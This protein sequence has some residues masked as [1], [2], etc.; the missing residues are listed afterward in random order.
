M[1]PNVDIPWSIHG[2]I[3]EYA[4]QTDQTIE[5]AY[6]ETLE[7][8]VRDLPEQ[9]TNVSLPSKGYKDFGPRL[10]RTQ[11]TESHEINNS[12][13]SHPFFYLG[14]NSMQIKTRKNDMSVNEFVDRLARIH[15]VGRL[16]S[17]WFTVHQLGGA[18]VG[19]GPA[20]LA[21]AIKQ[22]DTTLTDK[23]IPTYKNGHLIYIAKLAY[24]GEYLLIR[25]ELP[26]LS[27]DKQVLSN[28]EL[29]FIVEGVPVTGALYQRLANA[30]G[31]NELFNA[32]ECRLPQT[33][34]NAPEGSRLT[35]TEQITTEDENYED[36]S[37]TGLIVENPLQGNN[38]LLTH[39]KK[40]LTGPEGSTE[41]AA[42]CLDVLANYDE[43]YCD[44][45]HA[46]GLSEEREYEFRGLSATYIQPLFHRNST[47]NI[48]VNIDW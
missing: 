41:Q 11:G 31:F 2:K 38:D 47:W 12:V 1:R 40:E 14:E 19:R 43:L 24:E 18:L 30:F 32:T 3:K 5:E 36:P 48:S 37:V 46:H 26:R 4:E 44:L 34:F 22:L 9:L 15:N 20:N 25:A 45:T 8:G 33:G 10:I 35:V 13:T 21:T 28:V 29:R 27:G 42:S 16:S 7:Q 39:L 6:I 23:E 17:S